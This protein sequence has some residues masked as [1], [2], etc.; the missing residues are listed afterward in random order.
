MNGWSDRRRRPLLLA[1]L[2]L[3]AG[4]R[5][6]AGEAPLDDY[7]ARLGRITGAQT[8]LP[9]AV[10]GPPYPPQRALTLEIPSRTIDVAEFF[11]LHGCD[12]GALVGFRNSPLGRV[13]SASQRL[14]YEVA[15]L[16][17]VDGCGAETAEWLI[18]L[19]LDKRAELPA[20]FWNAT[21]AAGEL[22]VALGGGGGE[23]EGDLADL[24]RGLND[25]L[26]GVLEGGF[27]LA[28]MERRLGSLRQ[29]SWV[30]PARRDWAR[31]RRYLTAASTLLDQATP[32]ICPN[33]RPNVATGRLQNVFRRIYVGRLQ[34]ELARRM[35]VHEAWVRELERL[36]RR[37]ARVQ[38]PAFA[39]WFD[40]VLAPGGGSEWQRTRE[41][42]V[43]HARSWQRVFA[44]CG[45]EPG[46]GLSQD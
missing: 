16:R 29:G 14:G 45:V 11:E 27:E 4:C 1:A 36:S 41:A 2:V 34:P 44:F 38:P 5:G 26:T 20:L 31:W 42:V 32:G 10:P 43:A 28:A 24:L 21:F 13:Q 39:R 46:T 8:T 37:L 25:S 6:S 35:R 12:M 7:L 30:G 18:A 15:W 3:L 40:Q 33:R 23:A 17:A 19:Q 22:R 9:D